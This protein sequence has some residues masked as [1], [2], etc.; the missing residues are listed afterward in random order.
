MELV[1]FGIIRDNFSTQ[2]SHRSTLQTPQCLGGGG[3]GHT[4][5]TPYGILETVLGVHG[6][7]SC[8]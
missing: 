7:D 5:V 6:Q 3:R 4:E 8:S 1:I 2:A